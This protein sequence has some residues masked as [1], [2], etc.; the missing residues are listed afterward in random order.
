MNI[1]KYKNLSEEEKKH[2]C[3]GCGGKG[4]W[5]KPP[6]FRF[7]ASCNHHDFKFWK[8]CSVEDFHIANKDFYN[9]MKEDIRSAVWYKRAHYRIWAFLYYG[10]VSIG[11]KKYFYFA[12]KPK[13]LEDLK[14][15]MKTI[16][17]VKMEKLIKLCIVVAIG[18]MVGGCTVAEKVE[19][20][21]TGY[22]LTKEGIQTFVSEDTKEKYHAK[23][24]DKVIT[25]TYSIIKK[26]RQNQ[27]S[28]IASTRK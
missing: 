5:V 16:K 6:N 7:K 24:L 22:S 18:I 1:L 17:R 23:D 25:G 9:W 19:A 12:K 28:E 2:I 20:L 14:E 21:E 8:G 26:I 15:E 3:N 4:G 13:T 27:K 11:G 10:A